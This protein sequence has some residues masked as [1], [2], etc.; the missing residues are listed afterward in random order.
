M[1][2]VTEVCQ[3][4]LLGEADRWKKREI[5]KIYSQEEME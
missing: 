3:K 1:L 5:F 2:E 4:F